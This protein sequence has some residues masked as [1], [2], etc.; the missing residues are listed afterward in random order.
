MNGDFIR[1]KIELAGF[2]LVDVAK[3]LNITPQDLHSKLKSKDIKVSFLENIA[4]AI[5]KSV[6]FFF[7][8]KSENIVTKKNGDKN[9]DKKGDNPKV[10]EMSPFSMNELA[11]EYLKFQTPKVV[12]VDKTGNDNV[13]LVPVKAAAG[14]LSGYS[15][16]EFIR[17]LPTYNL[18][19]LHNGT[20]RMFQIGGH[21][22]YPTLHDGAYVVGEWV[23]DW[24]NGIKDNRIYIVVVRSTYAEGI[25][26]KRALNR[27]YK[28]GHL[29]L[30]SDNREYPSL[31]LLPQDILEVWEV[32]LYLG[33]ELPDPA[34]IYNRINDL[35]AEIEHLKTIVNKK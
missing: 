19:N 5:N 28:Y 23:E 11:A 32:K 34:T 15:D 30:K 1:K 17:S 12:T 9:G 22:M 29:Y 13:V 24:V 27:F 25:L 16:P 33:W 3:N 6:Y 7:E 14:Y 21:S 2:Q 18:P 31:T 20:F 4:K 26:V 8:T 10:K 35:E